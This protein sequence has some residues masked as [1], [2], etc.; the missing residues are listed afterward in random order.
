MTF[1]RSHCGLVV[2]QGYKPSGLTSGQR[3]RSSKSQPSVAVFVPGRT[4]AASVIS[5]TASRYQSK[6]PRIDEVPNSRDARALFSKSTT[7]VRKARSPTYT[8]AQSDRRYHR[9]LAGSQRR[10]RPGKRHRRGRQHRAG[11]AR[12]TSRW[13][14]P[15]SNRCHPAVHATAA[16]TRN[17]L[18]EYSRPQAANCPDMD[19]RE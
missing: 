3:R 4:L 19:R 1:N 7:D 18:G 2:K 12:H 5:M 6:R 9:V 13:E 15:F 10:A 8:Q 11:Y 14:I 17:R 16:R